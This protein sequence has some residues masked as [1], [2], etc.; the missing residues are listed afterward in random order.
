[1]GWV[2]HKIFMP[3]SFAATI[4]EPAVIFADICNLYTFFYKTNILHACVCMNHMRN[5][6]QLLLIKVQ[7]KFKTNFIRPSVTN[8]LSEVKW[9]TLSS[10]WPG[11]LSWPW[12]QQYL[13]LLLV[14]L[15]HPPDYGG[16]L[17]LDGK[18]FDSICVPGCNNLLVNWNISSAEILHQQSMRSVWLQT[19]LSM[20]L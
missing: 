9:T 8:I 12:G 6:C 16:Y 18:I 5:A 14:C 20:L 2:K 15:L 19:E 11:F 10:S 17:I 7:T 4:Y 13:R 1:M 3:R